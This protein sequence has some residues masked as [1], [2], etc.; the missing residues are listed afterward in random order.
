MMIDSKWSVR[1]LGILIAVI[2]LLS[3]PVLATNGNT[4]GDSD[5]SSSD[6]YDALNEG[7]A[8]YN[9][10]LSIVPQ[11]IL[12]AGGN[13]VILIDIEMEDG[14]NLIIEA[15]TNNGQITEFTEVSSASEVDPTVEITTDEATAW[16]VLES[17]NPLR[18]FV[19]SVDQGN[20]DVEVT[21]F[22]KNAALRAL[23]MLYSAF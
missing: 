9:E 2:L 16:A 5:S 3:T 20:S 11:L 21:G 12:T 8:M 1:V 17:D 6:L 19:E 13:D 23:L 10:N 4:T 18:T 15:A 7:V 22:I 14:S